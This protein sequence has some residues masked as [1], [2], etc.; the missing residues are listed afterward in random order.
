VEELLKGSRELSGGIVEGINFFRSEV[1]RIGKINAH[2]NAKSCHQCR[3]L[4]LGVVFG[5]IAVLASARASGSCYSG[6]WRTTRPL[7]CGCSASTRPSCTASLLSM[8]VERVHLSDLQPYRAWWG[9]QFSATRDGISE[10]PPPP[11]LRSSHRPTLHQYI[12]S[13]GP[14]VMRYFATSNRTSLGFHLAYCF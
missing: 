6:C 10:V 5:V 7:F 3:N 4:P 11:I 14:L 8:S 12:A 9:E 2:G 13:A 1:F